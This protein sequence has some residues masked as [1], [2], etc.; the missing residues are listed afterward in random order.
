[1]S[2]ESGVNPAQS[3]RVS[4]E[5]FVDCETF[6]HRQEPP[7]PYT[8][9]AATTITT[10][11]VVH[12]TIIVQ[13]SLKGGPILYNCPDCQETVLTTVKYVNTRK[14]HMLAGFICGFTW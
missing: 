7:P 11:P 12:Q 9:S 6:V 2:I 5:L 4:A 10:Q 1:M 8:P 14:T 13:T 3:N